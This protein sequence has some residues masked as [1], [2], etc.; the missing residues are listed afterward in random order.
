ML[1]WLG[2]HASTAGGMGSIPA[3][4]TKVPYATVH[5]QKKVKEKKHV[6]NRRTLFLLSTEEQRGCRELSQ[7]TTVAA[8]LLCSQDGGLHASKDWGETLE[9]W[10]NL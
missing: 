4:E 3:W 5:G 1:Q 6:S 8:P 7:R 9:R 2:P 10:Q